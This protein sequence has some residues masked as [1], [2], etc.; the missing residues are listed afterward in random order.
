MYFNEFIGFKYQTKVRA[1]LSNTNYHPY[2]MHKNAI[3]IIAVLDGEV[4]IFDSTLHRPLSTGDIYI[5]NAK[6]G[7][8]LSSNI[9]NIILTL[10][11][12]IDFF[13]EAFPDLVD[14]YFLCDSYASKEK[15]SSDL[16]QL[17]FLLSKLFFEYTSDSLNDFNLNACTKDIISLL[18]EKYSNYYYATNYTGRYEMHRK[19][20]MAPYTNENNRTYR[21][22]NYIYDHC[23]EEISLSD[24][25]QME[26]LSTAY[27]SRY[28]KNNAGLSFSELLSLARCDEAELLLINTQKSIDEIA[29][30]LGFANRYH[31]CK[32]FKKWFGKTPSNYRKNVLADLSGSTKIINLDFDYGEA[33]KTLN[34][35]LDGY[36]KSIS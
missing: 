26:F 35:Y 19:I 33:T 16:Y 7:H 18:I 8:K 17:R 34:A 6:E 28:I 11:I 21:I 14:A 12:D 15:D 1:S 24:I 27:L 13:S 22:I 36:L 2:H 29:M 20:E 10:H 9:N 31:L 4:D 3:E 23:R 5:F 30:E 25:A 32:N